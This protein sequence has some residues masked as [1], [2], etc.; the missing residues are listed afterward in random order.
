M[1]DACGEVLIKNISYWEPDPS[2][3]GTTRPPMK[4]ANTMCPGLC[5]GNG[6]CI[7]GTCQC[8]AN[9]TAADCSIDKNK[10]PSVKK[11]SSN[12]LCDVR[13]RKDCHLVKV[14]GRNFMNSRTLSCQATK[15]IVGKFYKFP[16]KVVCCLHGYS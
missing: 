14:T 9:Y 6:Q 3:N 4:M 11:I 13:K 10:G 1:Q 2:S 15:L 5:R 8:N 16:Q 12:G 7:N